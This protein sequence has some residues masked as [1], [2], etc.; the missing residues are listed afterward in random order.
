MIPLRAILLPLAGAL[1]SAILLTSDPA[2]AFVQTMTCLPSGQYQC[3]PG[4][5]P[6]PVQWSRLQ[7]HYHINEAGSDDLHQGLITEELR[8]S[9]IASFDTWNEP[10]CSNLELIYKE[11]TDRDEIG[12]IESLG[13]DNINVVVWR[14]EDWS[15]GSYA[16]VALTTVT[17]RPSTGFIV[18]ADIEMNGAM[19]VF[20]NTDTPRDTEVDVRNTLTHEVGHFLGLDH[21]SERNATMFGTAPPGE[22]QKR[23]LHPVDI[24]GVCH[25][26][27]DGADPPEVPTAVQE[28]SRRWCAALAPSGPAPS[29]WLGVL[30]L[31]GL[32]YSLRRRV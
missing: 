26:Y 14:D 13:A 17:F 19:Y 31:A 22:L 7:V 3:R 2:A 18:D 21:S 28:T 11:L 1:S 29:P 32:A 25:I 24:A 6:K 16:A 27:P 30:V 5:T 10:E 12:Y 23:D 8:Q 4:E 20:T 15:Y 9:I